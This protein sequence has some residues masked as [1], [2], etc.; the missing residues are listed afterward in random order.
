MIA[1]CHTR[2]CEKWKLHP[3]FNRCEILGTILALEYKIEGDLTR[4]LLRDR[5]YQFFIK[6]GVLLRPLGNV[7]YVLPPYCITAEELTFIYDQII[8]KLEGDV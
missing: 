8:L 5:L 4:Q 2:F 1:Q 7:L 3:K 6:K